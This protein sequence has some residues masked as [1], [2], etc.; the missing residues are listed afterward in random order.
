MLAKLKF[1]MTCVSLD[2]KMIY[3]DKDEILLIIN[4]IM[5]DNYNESKVLFYFDNRFFTTYKTNI[6]YIVDI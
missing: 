5:Q 3:I 1:N 6:I 2:C 4:K